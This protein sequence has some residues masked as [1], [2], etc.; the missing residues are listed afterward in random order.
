MPYDNTNSGV[1][2]KND[3]KETENHPD[4]TGKIN[5]NGDDFYLSAWINTAQKGEKEG[6]KYLSIKARP[7]EERVNHRPGDSSP[8]AHLASQN[9]QSPKGEEGFDDDIPF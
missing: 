8:S 2:F 9:L 1:L 7:V 3:R 4:Y 5:V 6:K